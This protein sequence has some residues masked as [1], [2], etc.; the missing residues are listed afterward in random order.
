MTAVFEPPYK[1][2]TTWRRHLRDGCMAGWIWVSMK[3][4]M[5]ASVVRNSAKEAWAR[6]RG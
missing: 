5:A 3:H 1:F 2:N 6:W 4:A